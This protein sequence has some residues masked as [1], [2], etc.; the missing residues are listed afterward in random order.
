MLGGLAPL[1]IRLGGGAL[2]GLTAE[3]H[4]RLA[5]DLAGAVRSCPFAV[6]TYTKVG[7]DVTFDSYNGMNGV[8]LEHVPTPTVTGAGEVTFE[9]PMSLEDPYGRGEPVHLRHGKVTCH[10]ATARRG[11]IDSIGRNAVRVITR[12]KASGVAEDCKVTVKVT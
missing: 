2:D 11:A 7:P 10:G 1:P 5:A 8:G 4:A 9:W 6:F 12:S 3:Q